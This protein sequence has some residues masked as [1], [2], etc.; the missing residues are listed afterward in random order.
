M[1]TTRRARGPRLEL[2]AY[3]TARISLGSTARM[4][5]TFSQMVSGTILARSGSASTTAQT[6]APG[7]GP[8][9][10]QSGSRFGRPAS[11][12]MTEGLLTVGRC[13]V[14]TMGTTQAMG[15]TTGGTTS[16]VRRTRANTFAEPICP[17]A[18]RRHPLHRPHPDRPGRPRH[19][20]PRAARAST[21]AFFP[22]RGWICRART[23]CATMAG[24][25]PSGPTVR[26]VPTAKTAVR[27][28]ARCHHRARRERHPRRCQ[29]RVS[30]TPSSLF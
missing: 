10:A 7:C 30:V 11:P 14:Q 9:V 18:P 20:S 2:I 1:S 17:R 16:P 3:F 21:T 28:A 24:L 8:T 5:T 12:M 4:R 23:A 27:A 29:R 6:K 22:A 26:T 19:H 15:T 13:G 25:A